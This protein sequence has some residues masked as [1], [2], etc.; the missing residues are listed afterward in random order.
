MDM[1]DPVN[2]SKI[3]EVGTSNEAQG[4]AMRPD[5]QY[6][7]VIARYNGS[8]DVIRT[9]DYTNIKT[10][11]IGTGDIDFSGSRG[12]LV[13]PDGQYVY[14]AHSY[15][16]TVSVIQTSDHTKIDTFNVGADIA[17]DM[18]WSAGGDYILAVGYLTRN[19]IAIKISDKSVRTLYQGT[20]S[21]MFLGIDLASDESFMLVTDVI[22]KKILLFSKSLKGY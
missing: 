18:K 6:V 19:I 10:I 2:P 11:S 12:I 15:D 16:H 5:G 4:I 8:V 22:Q 14:A 13:S 21:N 20:T 1:T 7:Y 3:T 17:F 9:S